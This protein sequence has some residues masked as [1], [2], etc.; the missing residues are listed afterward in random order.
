V[1][2]THGAPAPAVDEL[3]A[4]LIEASPR[5]DPDGQRLAVTVYRTL[6]E[7]SPVA[8]PVLAERTGI[9]AAEVARIL[10]AWPGVFRDGAGGIVGFW[11]LCLPETV[12][13]LRAGGRDLHTWCAWDTLFLAPVLDRPLE[14][15]SRCPDTG[16]E[17]SLTVAPAGIRT[18]DPAPTVLSFLRPERE[19]A[20][21]IITTFCHHV[22]CLESPAAGTRWLAGRPAGFLVGLDDGFEL[23][24]RF[25]EA[26]F[27]AALT[28]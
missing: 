3:A 12:H 28:G 6:A 17:I 16:R 11:G 27:G 21:D 5:L 23:G 20:D 26:R 24:R 2:V 7:G 14:V 19:W 25:V 8:E 15:S 1:D 13:R 10:D 4:A 22:R 18:V 9:A